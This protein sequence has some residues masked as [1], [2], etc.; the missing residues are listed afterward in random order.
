M[1]RV[2]KTEWFRQG[3]AR[4]REILRLYW[5][6]I[7]LDDLPLDEY[8]SYADMAHAM[9]AVNGRLAEDV[10]AYLD[11]I[12]EHIIEMPT[13]NGRIVAQIVAAALDEL[14]QQPSVDE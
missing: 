10:G 13:G 1:A 14:G 4:T 6:P 2:D 8:D 7:G 3:R 12:A 9:L 5:N 11:D